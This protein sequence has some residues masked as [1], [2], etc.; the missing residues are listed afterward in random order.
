[1][2]TKSHESDIIC[3]RKGAKGFGLILCMIAALIRNSRLGITIM[4]DGGSDQSVDV[5]DVTC[6][7]R[8]A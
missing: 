8:V 1:M 3:R 6:S 2:G 5:G 7:T 4:V